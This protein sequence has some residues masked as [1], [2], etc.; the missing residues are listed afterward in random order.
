MPLAARYPRLRVWIHGDGP[1]RI[2]VSEE[3]RAAGIGQ[4]VVMPG[5]FTEMSELFQAADACVFPGQDAGLSFLLPTCLRNRIPI[6]IP[7]SKSV[8]GLCGDRSRSSYFE[9]RDYLNL[10]DRICDWMDDS[11]ALEK[12]ALAMQTRFNC[13]NEFPSNPKSLFEG[14]DDL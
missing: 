2:K 12:D 7:N 10:R 5:V 11:A 13:E 6:L 1:F 9:A 4:T 3:I 8:V 14:L